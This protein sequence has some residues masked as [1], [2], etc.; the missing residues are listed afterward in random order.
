[1]TGRKV[2]RCYCTLG[3]R[4][5]IDVTAIAGRNERMAKLRV[6]IT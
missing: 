1:M 3:R 2:D 4:Y 6:K 5:D